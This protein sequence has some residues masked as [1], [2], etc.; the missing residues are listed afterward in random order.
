MPRT[1]D[2]SAG[3]TAFVFAAA[4]LA[5]APAANA[6]LY[7]WVDANGRVVYSDQAPLG[8]VKAE[9]VGGAPPPAN[10]NALKEMQGKDAEFRK[11]Q[12]DRA[13]DAKKVEASRSDTQKLAAFCQQVRGQIAALGRVD[14][15]LFRIND[16]GERVP[17]DEAARRAESERLEQMM[18]E[19]KCPPA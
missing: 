15:V 8:N 9:I 12:L 17:M 3:T 16:K 1:N 10:P 13:D 18:R 11:R 5:A 14:T 19:R 4:L 7:K 6:A 2:R